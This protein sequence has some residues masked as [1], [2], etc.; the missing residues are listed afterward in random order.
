MSYS[1]RRSR[2]RVSAAVLTS[3]ALAAG[4]LALAAP[5]GAAVRSAAPARP[6]PYSVASPGSARPSAASPRRVWHLSL[7]PMPTGYAGLARTATGQ[8][9]ATVSAFGFTPGSAHTVTLTDSSGFVVT[10]F[11]VLT[12]NSVGQAYGVTLHSSYTGRLYAGSRLVIDN[13]TGSSGVSRE[14]IAISGPL[15]V[16]SAAELETVTQDAAG[17]NFGTPEGTATIVYSPSAQT[18]A[19][20]VNATG[21]TPGL[22]AA[23]IHVGSCQSQGPVEYMIPDFRGTAGGRIVNQT[24]VV[25]GVTT[26]IPASGWYFNLH[27]GNSSQIVS[28]GQPTIWFRPL[29][30]ANIF[31]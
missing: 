23:H 30:C 24:R 20:T 31:G 25:T 18:L 2:L 1:S 29:L 19:V 21:V 8:L 26:P 9:T 7:M 22:H 5:A 12:A 11:S 17:Q 13:G 6:V 14:V 4:T 15:T 10:T 3:G 28:N 16:G 27:L